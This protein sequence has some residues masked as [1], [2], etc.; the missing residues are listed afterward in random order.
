MT[1]DEITAQADDAYNLA[2]D[3]NKAVVERRL[4]KL[5]LSDKDILI[6]KGEW[7]EEELQAFAKLCQVRNMNNILVVIPEEKSL[8][9][10]PIDDFFFLLKEVEKKR[11]TIEKAT[12][13]TITDISAVT[14]L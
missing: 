8:E 7:Q 9:T 3:K 5:E 14:D 10:M 1:D 4:D 12:K 11:E 13:T 6:F 2:T